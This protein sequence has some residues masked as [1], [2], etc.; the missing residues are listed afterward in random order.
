MDQIASKLLE[1]VAPWLNRL[2][3]IEIYSLVFKF[4]LQAKQK[5]LSSRSSVCLDAFQWRRALF[6]FE[7]ARACS[8]KTVPKYTL[9]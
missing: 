4:A 1:K 9:R 8:H 6:L 7:V 2:F 3:K 5:S